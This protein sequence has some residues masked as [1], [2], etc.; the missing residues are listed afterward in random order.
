MTE[1]KGDA[2][3]ISGRVLIDVSDDELRAAFSGPAVL[4]N[5]FYTTLG[6]SGVRL[7]FMEALGDRVPPIF[8]AAVVLPYQDALALRDLLTAQLSDID[9]IIPPQTEPQYPTA[10]AAA[11]RAD[12]K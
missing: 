1:A 10:K 8:R 5:K 2:G 12:A 3:D 7:A 11:E 4:S 9:V 6:P